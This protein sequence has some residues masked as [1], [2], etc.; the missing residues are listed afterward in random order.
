MNKFKV[1]GLMSGSSMDGV[2]IAYCEFS[3]SENSWKYNI[4][5]AETV[6]YPETWRVRLSKLYKQDAITY[7]RTDIFYG[8]YLG[9]LVK[10]F[11]KKYNLE[12]DFVA[13]HGHTIFHDPKTKITRQVGDGASLSAIC[14]LPVINDFRSMDVAKGGEGAPLVA[15]GDKILFPEYDYCLNLGGFANISGVYNNSRIAYDICAA[16]ILLNRVARDLG[17]DYDEDGKIAENGSIN[18]ELLQ[19]LNSIPFFSKPFPKSLS[20]EWI[21]EELWGQVRKSGFSAEDKMKT[22]VDHIGFQI[23]SSVNLLSGDQSEGKT[24]LITGGGAYNKTLISH[25]ESHTDAKIVIPEND[26]IEFKEAVI[27]ALLG[28]L[29]VNNIVNVGSSYTGASSDSI[30]G[31]LH[32]KIPSV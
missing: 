20:R 32:G 31:G 26:V 1:I 25:I 16:N 13:S 23:G 12:V 9:A 14:G 7:A 17:F 8:H 6:A 5:K 27:F 10:E 24:L 19:A 22:L 18:Y 11:V 4:I 2:D 21:N 3:G 29:R 30:A 28:V 15:I